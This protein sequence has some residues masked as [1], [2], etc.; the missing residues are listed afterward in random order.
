M[1]IRLCREKKEW[2]DYFDKEKNIEFLQSWDW[3]EFQQS[4]GNEVIR[5]QV[6]DGEEVMGQIQGFVQKLPFG[7]GYL[8]IP[9]VYFSNEKKLETRNWKPKM[10]KYIKE[11]NF[12]F[13]RVE[14]V[15]NVSSFLF[16]VSFTK[17]R[18]PQTTLVLD[19]SK[20]EEILLSEMHAKTRYNIRLAEKK[21]VIVKQQKNVE[22]FWK[23]NEE[24]S[25]RDEF[26]THNF[27]YYKKMIELDMVYELTAY[28]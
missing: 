15:N 24:T 18:Q 14:L 13:A 6:V 16:P 20:S 22:D 27:N 25:D 5:L 2:D 26:T 17:N 8:Y 11:K 7:L 1:K 9:R 4:V 28:Y 21:G 19:I 3:G 10:F 23:L 12:V